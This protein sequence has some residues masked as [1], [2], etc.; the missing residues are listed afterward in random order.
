MD[1]IKLRKRMAEKQA[2]LRNFERQKK[3][4]AMTSEADFRKMMEENYTFS[5]GRWL[6][7]QKKK[8]G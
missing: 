8:G 1:L 6:P 7:K 2:E 3:F 4:F 5:E